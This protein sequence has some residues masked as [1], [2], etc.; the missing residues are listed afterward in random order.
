MVIDNLVR[1]RRQNI[2]FDYEAVD[3]S[4]T[5]GMNLK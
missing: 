4:V 1:P 2:L 3:K 5:E